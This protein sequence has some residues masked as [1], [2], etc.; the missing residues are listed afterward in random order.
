MA[1]SK[2]VSCRCCYFKATANIWFKF[3]SEFFVLNITLS[4]EYS[5]SLWCR[6]DRWRRPQC[7]QYRQAKTMVHIIICCFT[8]SR[9]EI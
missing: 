2:L 7:T 8:A 5:Q 1:L 6:L 4:F 3:F 9:A